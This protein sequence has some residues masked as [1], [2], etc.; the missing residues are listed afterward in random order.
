MAF[1]HFGAG[2]KASIVFLRRRA[3]DEKLSDDEPIFMAIAKRIGYDATGRKDS[4]ND[5]KIICEEY[6]RFSDE[7]PDFF[8]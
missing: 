6:R 7:N 3:D 2:V 1:A 8:G 5:F 4:I